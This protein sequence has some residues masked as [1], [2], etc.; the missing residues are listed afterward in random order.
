MNTA[1]IRQSALAHRSRLSP[2]EVQSASLEIAHRLWSLPALSRSPKIAFY[3]AISGEVDCE[4]A[5][6][7]AWSRGRKVYLP[8]LMQDEIRF[9]AYA[10]NSKILRNRYQIPEPATKQCELVH[11]REI[12][13]VITPLVAFDTHMNRI[14][15]G[16]GYYDRSFRFMKNRS[17]WKRPV[18]VGVAYEFQKVPKLKACS[19]DI[20]LHF[21]VTEKN[22][23]GLQT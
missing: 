11:P 2:A 22:T 10:R 21:V 9:G 19:W 16:G 14:G 5:I 23:Y 15:M 4:F 3:S 13:V 6:E 1:E 12:D 17:N 20:P 18:L 8:I 7:K